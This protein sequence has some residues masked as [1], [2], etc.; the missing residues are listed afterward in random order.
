[1]LFAG[2]DGEIF[3]VWGVGEEVKSFDGF[4]MV[5]FEEEL[6]VTSLG[7]WVTG[8]VNYCFRFNFI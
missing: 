4:D 8:K 2:E 1:M 5:V 3:D 6:D 7:G